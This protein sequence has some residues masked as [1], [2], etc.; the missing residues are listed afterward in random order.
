MSI[1]CIGHGIMGAQTDI[2]MQAGASPC[3]CSWDNP[4]KFT[5]QD[6]RCKNDKAGIGCPALHVNQNFYRFS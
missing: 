6:Q 3:Y 5:I 4:F 2:C 1:A